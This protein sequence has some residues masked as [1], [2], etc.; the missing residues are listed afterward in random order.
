ME[1][2]ELINRLV[3]GDKTW[4]SYG[5]VDTQYHSMVWS[6]TAS[7]SKQQQNPQQ[8]LSA[9]KIMTGVFLDEK[10]VVFVEFMGVWKIINSNLYYESLINL[11]RAN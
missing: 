8:T 9:R 2:E 6:Y 1:G 4:V 3:T 10:G 11:R 5:I 7:P